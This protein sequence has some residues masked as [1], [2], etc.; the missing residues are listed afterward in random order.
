[1]EGVDDDDLPGFDGSSAE[2]PGTG[3]LPK[4]H[5]PDMPTIYPGDESGGVE[6]MGDGAG[7]SRE[8]QIAVGQKLELAIPA[9][10]AAEDELLNSGRPSVREYGVAGA[11][12]W[13]NMVR[14]IT[15]VLL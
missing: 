9:L 2:P 14:N 11:I 3:G 4:P 12:E 1:M 15:P 5:Y 10:V 8:Q 13:I 6:Q 7:M